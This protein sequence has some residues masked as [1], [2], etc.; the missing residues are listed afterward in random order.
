[1]KEINIRANRPCIR[2]AW[3]GVTRD[4]M[5]II[6]HDA[7]AIE[8][9]DMRSGARAPGTFG[10]PGTGPDFEARIRPGPAVN[11]HHNSQWRTHKTPRPQFVDERLTNGVKELRHGQKKRMNG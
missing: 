6:E 11:V 7:H 9:T 2:A 10:I 8:I 5:D 4:D 3:R 1:M